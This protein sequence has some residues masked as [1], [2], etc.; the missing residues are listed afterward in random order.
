MP[1]TYG[2]PEATDYRNGVVSIGNFDGVH[3]GHQRILN[4]L[5]AQAHGQNCASVVLTF[6]P[7]PIQ[8]L[9]PEAAPARLTTLQ[10]KAELI[11]N[12]GV[13]HVIAY[14]TDQQFLNL[15]P[16]QF[17]T[18]IVREAL[19][20]RGLV[21]GPNFFFGKGRAGSIEM[22]QKLCSARQMTLQV[23][24]PA[25][26]EQGM[27]SSSAIRA[28]LA[29]G[30]VENAR[31]Q[32]GR[33][34]TVSGRVVTG[35]QRGRTI[36]FPTANLAEI[37]T[38]IPADGVYACRCSIDGEAFA[39]AVSIGGNPTFSDSAHK[40]EAHILEFNGDLYQT[41]LEVEF[42]NR[43]RDMQ[44][45]DSQEELSRQLREDIQQTRQIFDQLS[46]L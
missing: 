40:V 30:H 23:V 6:E 1:F 16:Q 20:A 46:T 24:S 22:L 31:G 10:Q 33:P 2:F 45:F 26:S 13:E 42:L 4:E 9:R 5:T 41:T 19:S 32:L 25:A 29:G 7:H 12:C 37:A 15:D 27:I 36:G 3:L 44:T 8:I 43:L 39:A 38:M 21:E 28:A 18:Q 11:L 34:Y 17:F 14:P 35:A